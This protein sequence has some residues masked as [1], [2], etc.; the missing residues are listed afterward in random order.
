MRSHLISFIVCVWYICITKASRVVFNLPM[1][2]TA[3]TFDQLFV[4]C[5]F[6]GGGGDMK[7]IPF[8]SEERKKKKEEEAYPKNVV[9]LW[10]VACK[11]I[12]L[13]GNQSCSQ[14]YELVK[15]VTCQGS[16]QGFSSQGLW[17]KAT[18]LERGPL[19]LRQRR[20]QTLKDSHL[21][22]ESLYSHS[23]FFLRGNDMRAG[24][25][26]VETRIFLC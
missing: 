10:V 9:D 1:P 25:K 2:I 21:L 15:C 12:I 11:P 7:S 4:E 6:S 20:S 18:S 3:L 24:P 8:L 17:I 19:L 14:C 26:Y 22:P 23:F 13:A 16:S 5:L